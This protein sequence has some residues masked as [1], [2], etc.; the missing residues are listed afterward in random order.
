VT[1]YDLVKHTAILG[2]FAKLQKVTASVRPSVS[3]YEKTRLPLDGYSQNL[4]F[5]YVTKN[6]QENSSFKKKKKK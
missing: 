4:I 5:E 2:A 6:S 1:W 3:P